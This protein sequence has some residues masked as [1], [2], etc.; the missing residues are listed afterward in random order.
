MSRKDLFHRRDHTGGVMFATRG[1]PYSCDFCALAVMYQSRVRKRRVDAVAEEYGS[2]PGKVIILWDDK[3]AS[4]ME[5]ADVARTCFVGARLVPYGQEKAADLKDRSALP[6]L[7]LRLRR[8][9][10]QPDRIKRGS[11]ASAPQ[12]SHR[13]RAGHPRPC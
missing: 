10:Q 11:K 8:A 12:K 5:R 13:V 7:H 6:F 1:C 2:F 4:D 3:I 9:A